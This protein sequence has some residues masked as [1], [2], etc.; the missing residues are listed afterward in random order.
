MKRIG[1]LCGY[2][3]IWVEIQDDDSLEQICRKIESKINCLE[4]VFH[5]ECS[6]EN[7]IIKINQTS[8]V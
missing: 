7:G 3:S 4:R 2:D 6:V 5:V 8:K 1:F